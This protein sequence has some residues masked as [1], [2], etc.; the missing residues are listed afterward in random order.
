MKLRDIDYKFSMFIQCLHTGC[1][2]SFV[3]ERKPQ[4]C[5]QEKV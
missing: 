5:D 2:V 1:H 3:A 4:G